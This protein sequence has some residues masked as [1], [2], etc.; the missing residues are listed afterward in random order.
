MPHLT[1]P[2]LT[3]G[4]MMQAFIGVSEAMGAASREAGEQEPPPVSANGLVVDTG[5]D[6]SRG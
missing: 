4:P 5:G 1:L 2:I 6:V 3:P